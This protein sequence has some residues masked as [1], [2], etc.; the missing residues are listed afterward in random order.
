MYNG[1]NCPFSHLCNISTSCWSFTTNL[2]A[3][4]IIDILTCCSIFS[5]V[6]AD[7][8]ITIKGCCLS[9]LTDYPNTCEIEWNAI[10]LKPG[11]K[12]TLCEG[13]YLMLF[14]RTMAS[15]KSNKALQSER[16]SRE[17]L[18]KIF[19]SLGRLFRSNM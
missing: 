16:R 11:N 12:L 17:R 9:P 6:S 1:W 15:G 10:N 3:N 18:Y 13:N 19:L 5:A 7:M 8:Q 14:P 2:E 4:P